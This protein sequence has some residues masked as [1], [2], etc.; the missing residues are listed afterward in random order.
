MAILELGLLIYLLIFN[1]MP[2]SNP[3]NQSLPTP[4]NARGGEETVVRGWFNY[5]QT[6]LANFN[7]YRNRLAGGSGFD[8]NE[9]ADKA[10]ISRALFPQ[11]N[12][13]FSTLT[14]GA[15]INSVPSNGTQTVFTAVTTAFANAEVK[16]IG[17]HTIEPSGGSGNYNVIGYLERSTSSSFTSPTLV[18]TNTITITAVVSGGQTAWGNIIVNGV[19]A[20]ATSGT[21]YYRLRVALNNYNNAATSNNTILLTVGLLTKSNFIDYEVTN[22]ST[23]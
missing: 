1:F 17:Q 2:F 15:S 4:A 14:H 12:R 8:S 16:L 5:W 6:Y 18:S 11:R 22:G 7:S 19:D 9:I 3:T 23:V 20:L 21:Y 13:I 10:I